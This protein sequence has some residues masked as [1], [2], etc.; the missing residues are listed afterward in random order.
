M[1]RRMAIGMA[2]FAA[3]LLGSSA[4]ALAGVGQG[5]VG[6]GLVQT[7]EGLLGDFQF[8][9]HKAIGVIEGAEVVRVT[10]TAAFRTVL[11]DRAVVEINC[12][13]VRH[14]VLGEDKKSAE[15]S[16]PAVMFVRTQQGVRRV[17]GVVLWRAAD[18]GRPGPMNPPDLVG[19]H[20]TPSDGSQRF[21][22]GGA[23]V[24][25]DVKVFQVNDTRP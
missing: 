15:F 23:V 10:G 24:R 13:N 5:A 19:V 18:R 22:F 1:N 7:E 9:A 12:K 8:K 20:F 25:G 2:A 21:D 16:G 4:I 11:P 6:N 3:F 17:P 14:F